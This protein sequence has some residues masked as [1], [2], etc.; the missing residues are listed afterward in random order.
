MACSNSTIISSSNTADSDF[1]TTS[2]RKCPRVCYNHKKIGSR[3]QVGKRELVKN[4]VRAELATLPPPP[5]LQ[6]VVVA[7]QP[8]QV[9]MNSMMLQTANDPSSTTYSDQYSHF[10]GAN[11]PAENYPPSTG[12]QNIAE[13]SPQFYP[14]F[15]SPQI[16]VY[17]TIF[18]PELAWLRVQQYPGFFMQA[19]ANLRM[20]YQLSQTQNNSENAPPQHEDTQL[21]TAEVSQTAANS[22]T[23]GAPG[24]VTNQ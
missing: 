2:K 9:P 24:E 4:E 19:L 13:G 7:P 16:L 11:L 14:A 18:N 12:Y 15:Q 5:S 21:A 23:Y 3:K 20:P 1:R 10:N 8:V 22:K 6:P 17:S